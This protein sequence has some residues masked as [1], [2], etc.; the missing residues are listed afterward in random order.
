MLNFINEYKDIIVN[1]VSIISI[2]FTVSSLVS[3]VYISP[4]NGTFR[5]SFIS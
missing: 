2:A 4:D 3:L 5:K 1:V